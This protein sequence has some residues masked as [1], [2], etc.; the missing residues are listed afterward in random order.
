MYKYQESCLG[1]G[2]GYNQVPSFLLTWSSLV[3]PQDY[4]WQQSKYPH[5][6]CWWWNRHKHHGSLHDK[7][8][9]AYCTIAWIFVGGCWVSTKEIKESLC[10]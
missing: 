4:N 7:K 10:S 6:N 1:I 3:E 2:V 5:W 9:G 8:D